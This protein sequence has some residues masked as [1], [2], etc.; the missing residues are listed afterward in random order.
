VTELSESY[1]IE[2]HPRRWL[3]LAILNLC[4]VLIVASVSSL[5]VAIPTI[6][7]ELQPSSSQQ[8]WII[9][10][11]ALVFA[12]FLLPAGAL[13]DRYGRKGALL[14]GLAIFGVASCVAAFSTSPTQLIGMR[15]VMGIGAALIMP[16]TLSIITVVFPPQERSKAIAIWAGFAGAGGA[17][18]PLIS[19]LLLEAGFWWGSVFFVAVPIVVVAAVAIAIVVPTSRDE[20]GRPLDV[21]GAVFSV[22]GLTSLV[23]AIIEGPER[24][25]TDPL[26]LGLAV[27][28]VVFIGAFVAWELRATYPMLDPR[29]F[30]IRRFGFGSLAITMAFMVMFGFFLLITLYLQLVQG[31]SPLGAAVRTLPMPITLILVSP[32]SP[33]LVARFGL[34]RVVSIGF[35]IQATGF[36]LLTQ[37]DVDTSY[38][39]LAAAFVCLGAGMALLMPPSTESIVSSVSHDKAGVASAVNDTTREVGGAIGIALLGTLLATGYRDGL[40]STTDG[41]PPEAAEIVEDGLGGALQVAEQLPA[42]VAGPLVASARV[43][44]LDGTTLAFGVAVVLGLFTAV[45]VARGLRPERLEAERQSTS[46]ST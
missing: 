37:L 18:G 41:L 20:A 40:G 23:A 38:P 10:A 24:G 6:I 22:I 27:S 39:K 28:A 42:E 1:V 30:R 25:W 19:G 15:A 2:G 9:D 26:V 17:I 45:A 14:V 44:F 34:H 31:H 8:L 5:N 35:V 33:K 4:L 21:T 32:Q 46:A 43:A 16:A 36:L 3:I 7:R 12:G 11:Y 13:G 29:L